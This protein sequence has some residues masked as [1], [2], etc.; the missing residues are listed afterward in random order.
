MFIEEAI[1]VL[2][3]SPDQ[4]TVFSVDGFVQDFV[5]FIEQGNVVETGFTEEVINMKT[6]VFGDIAHILVLYES[7]IPGKRPPTPGVDSFQLIKRGERWWIA[8][9]TNEKPTAAW[10]MIRSSGA[11]PTSRT[12]SWRAGRSRISIR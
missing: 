1:V 6:M 8:S 4:A 11:I 10:P 2:R 3:T 7:S 12:A 5:T 9:V